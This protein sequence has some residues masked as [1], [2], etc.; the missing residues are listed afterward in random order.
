MMTGT[1]S[2][3]TQATPSSFMCLDGLIIRNEKSCMSHEN[4]NS[5]PKL[6]NTG[7]SLPKLN[8]RFSLSKLVTGFILLEHVTILIY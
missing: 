2:S 4:P 3:S 6:G 1:G 5:I 7:Y 8:I